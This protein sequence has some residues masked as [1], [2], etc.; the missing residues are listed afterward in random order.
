MGKKA[1][2]SLDKKLILLVLAVSL[3][4]TAA[5]TALS[6]NLID[7]IL[8]EKIK[9]ELLE[10]STLRGNAVR[11]LLEDR[12]E[13]MLALSSSPLIKDTVRE[14]SAESG[15]GTPGD[16]ILENEVPVLVEIR[17]FQL[18]E[19]HQ[20]EL[21]DV[22]V[23]GEGLDEHVVLGD[24][25][26]FP[27]A[28]RIRQLAGDQLTEFV[29]GPEGQVRLAAAVPVRD[30]LDG[31]TA[32]V[33]AAIMDTERL[34]RILD[35]REGLQETGEVYM[36]NQDRVMISK[37]IFVD[38]AEFNQRVDTAPVSACFDGNREIHGEVYQD[39]RGA[40]IFGISHC[41]SDRGY[42]VLTEMDEDEVLIPLFELQ[43]D[44]IA[45]S[46]GI[47]AVISGTAYW[48]SRRLSRPIRRLTEAAREISEGNFDVKTGIRTSDEIGELSRSFDAMAR[49]LLE[50]EITLSKQKEIIEQQEG[51][52]LRFS[53]RTE[54]ACVCFIDINESTKICAGLSDA[55]TTSLYSEF[56]NSMAALIRKYGGT[57]VKNIG[58]ALLFYFR[59]GVDAEQK[60]FRN[61]LECCMALIDYHDGLCARLEGGGLPRIDY[62]VSVTFGPVSMASVSTS[63]VDDVFGSTVNLCAKI[64]SYAEPNGLVV[65][66]RMY[67]KAG[68]LEGFEFVNIRDFRMSENRDLKIFAVRRA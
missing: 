38:N 21:V 40:K 15:H 17:N 14:L 60:E 37:S 65:G 34:D 12:I 8:K 23:F 18:S 36:V 64:N 29:Q 2:F 68:G 50:S 13:K 43:R 33:V 66:E 1:R 19:G 62:R 32:G 42:V 51:I 53:D 31:D 5:T 39:Y 28:G 41:Q 61:V 45:V 49:R 9:A 47:M 57:V 4:A 6:L 46:V 7:G 3:I 58:D 67:G 10:E 54:N 63:E 59:I 52:L 55:E 11:I 35:S 16:S 26:G 56:I 24:G 22:I 44:I 25:V 48:L 20:M 27:P 30:G